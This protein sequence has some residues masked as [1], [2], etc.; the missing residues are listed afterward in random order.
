V[1]ERSKNA[2]HSCNLTL[3][4]VTLIDVRASTGQLSLGTDECQWLPNG[5]ERV[6]MQ[7]LAG[8]C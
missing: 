6:R 1:N 4:A 5:S 2:L 8:V 3:T 7:R